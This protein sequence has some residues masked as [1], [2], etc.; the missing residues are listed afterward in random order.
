[1]FRSLVLPPAGD[2][3]RQR[4]VTKSWLRTKVLRTP[5]LPVLGRLSC[6]F[7]WFGPADGCKGVGVPLSPRLKRAPLVV[8]GAGPSK[9]LPLGERGEALLV[10][11][12]ATAPGNR[13]AATDEGEHRRGAA[14]LQI[15][16]KK[17]CTLPCNRK[18]VHHERCTGFLSGPPKNEPSPAGGRCP[19]AHTGADEGERLQS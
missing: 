8:V 17:C 18:P 6:L 5:F 13:I 15:M 12:E 19:S 3:S 9:S 16:R 1:M 11:E 10:A 14:H 7:R 4:K 2:F